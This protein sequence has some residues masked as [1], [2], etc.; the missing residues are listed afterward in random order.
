[1]TDKE[2]QFIDS[3]KNKIEKYNIH[4]YKTGEKLTVKDCLQY[5]RN[6]FVMT[7][8]NDGSPDEL[9]EVGIEIFYIDVA[10][11]FL[12]KNMVLLNFLV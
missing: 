11:F 5:W 9:I 1:M 2:K 4:N 8:Y 10:H 3:I 12:L 7:H 6:Q